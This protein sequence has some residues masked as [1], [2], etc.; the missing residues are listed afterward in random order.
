MNN[1]LEKTDAVVNDLFNEM[2]STVTSYGPGAIKATLRVNGT[3]F[4]PGGI[5]LWR[6][7]EKHGPIPSYFPSCPVMILGHNFDKVAGLEA[8]CKRGV[9]LMNGSTWRIL[10]RYLEAANVDKSDCFFTNVFVGLQPI[11]SLGEMVAD[12]DYKKQCRTFLHKQISRIKPRLVATIG[13]PAAEQYALSGCSAPVVELRHPSYACAKGSDGEQCAS[14]VALEA[15][16]LRN[17]LD[18]LLPLL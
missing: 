14:I 17:T 4:F 5:G 1:P 16:K 8:S 7:L 9:E 18:K 11:R 6:G 10:R 3:A 13:L 15:A 2:E 12:E